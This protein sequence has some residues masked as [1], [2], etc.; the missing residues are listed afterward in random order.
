M[1]NEAYADLFQ[2]FA[3]EFHEDWVIDAETDNDVIDRFIAEQ[4]GSQR[5]SSL[6]ERIDVFLANTPDESL[7]EFRHALGA[8]ATRD[9]PDSLRWGVEAH[10]EERGLLVRSEFLTRHR[11]GRRQ[12]DDDRG[13]YVL[14]GFRITPRLQLIAR[15][16]DFQRPQIGIGRRVRTT[17]IGANYE[18]APNRV[19]LLLNG[20]RRATG[21]QQART[22]L[23]VGQVQ[24]RF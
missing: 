14:G 20:I 16:E 1:E 7:E 3:G 11:R 19:R 6:A 2:F 5:L 23:L 12:E 15:E 8:N 4:P 22:D 17:T 18:I 10:I 9:G 21:P 13:W 24:I